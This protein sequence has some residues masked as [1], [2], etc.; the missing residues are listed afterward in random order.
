LRDGSPPAAQ[1]KR[2][3]SRSPEPR[4]QL[5]NVMVDPIF[6]FQFRIIL[7]GDSAVGKSSLLR[8]FT[9]GSFAEVSDP[10][11][12]VD[13]F[14]RLVRVDDGVTTIKLQ[15][16]D[17]AGQERFRSITKAYYRNSV[18]VLLVYDISDRVSFANLEQ[19]MSEARRH[20]E[21]HQATF[22]LVGCKQDMAKGR[23]V[24]PEEAQAFASRQ[25]MAYFETSAK[26]GHG[27]DQPFQHLAQVIYNKIKSGEYKFQDGWDGIK[28]SYFAHSRYHFHGTE[29]SAAAPTDA[30][31]NSSVN[32]AHGEPVAS[33]A[34]CC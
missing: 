4:L 22:V 28:R 10:T 5:N 25:R 32:L 26:R 14:A 24:S 8:K 29:E 16:W 27:V 11:V 15:L 3:E 21:P 19:W 7:I 20:I 12:G 33:S 6:D 9:F 2:G 18:G 31:N 17:T 30:S 1:K 13:F 34:N 23:Q